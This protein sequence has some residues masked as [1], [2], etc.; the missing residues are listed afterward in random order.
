MTVIGG[1]SIYYEEDVTAAGTFAYY[2]DSGGVTSGT[3]IF[4]GGDERV[5]SGSLAVSTTVCRR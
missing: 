1:G 2:V 3:A 5:F 4:S